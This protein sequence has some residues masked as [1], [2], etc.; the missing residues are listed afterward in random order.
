[1]VTIVLSLLVEDIVRPWPGRGE[2]GGGAPWGGG[3][4]VQCV[5][6]GWLFEYAKIHLGSVC[7]CVDGTDVD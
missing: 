4:E 6:E 1:M 3:Q 2:V 7:V 5:I